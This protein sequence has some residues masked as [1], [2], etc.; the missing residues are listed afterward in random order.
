MKCVRVQVAL[1]FVLW[2]VSMILYSDSQMQLILRCGNVC[3]FIN[4]AMI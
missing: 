1:S 4:L 2:R 3:R